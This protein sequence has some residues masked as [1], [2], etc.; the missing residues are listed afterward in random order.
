MTACHPTT[1]TGSPLAFLAAAKHRVERR[2]GCCTPQHLIDAAHGD[3][4]LHTISGGTAAPA[5]GH[6]TV[7]KTAQEP[8]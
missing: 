5:E 1:F 6:K 8:R 7:L 4:N 3:D 2:G